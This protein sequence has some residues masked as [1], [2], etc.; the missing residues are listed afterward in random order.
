LRNIHSRIATKTI[1]FSIRMR[2]IYRGESAPKL[3]RFE[4]QMRT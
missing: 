1:R 2:T 4:V 3:S